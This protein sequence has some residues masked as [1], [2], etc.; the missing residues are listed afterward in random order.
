MTTNIG[1][2]KVLSPKPL[3]FVVPSDDDLTELGSNLALDEVRKQL[4]PELVNRIDEIVVFNN[5]TKDNLYDIVDI[6]FKLYEARLSDNYQIKVTL[7]KTAKDFFI[8]KGYDEKYGAR[9]LNRVIQRSFETSI[10]NILLR[11][12]YKAGDEIVCYSKAD[13]LH[14]RKKPSRDIS[15]RP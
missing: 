12:K 13:K 10:A 14:F 3:G 6:N 15:K 8:E 9:E 11:K 2:E 5:L 7:D 4:K 1:A